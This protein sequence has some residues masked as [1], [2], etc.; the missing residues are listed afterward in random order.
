MK[1]EWLRTMRISHGARRSARG[2]AWLGPARSSSTAWTLLLWQAL[3]SLICLT[4]TARFASPIRCVT[5]VQHGNMLS[6]QEPA[7]DDG[8]IKCTSSVLT[9]DI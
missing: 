4:P 7:L 5:H 8:G 2:S 9:V 3:R 6:T 1:L